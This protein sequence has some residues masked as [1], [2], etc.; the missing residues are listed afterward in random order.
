M[1]GQANYNRWVWWTLI[2]GIVVAIPLILK[3]MSRPSVARQPAIASEEIPPLDSRRFGQ[4]TQRMVRCREHAFRPTPHLQ[5]RDLVT[6]D[7][8]NSVLSGAVPVWFPPTIPSLLHELKLWGVRAS[9]TEEMIGRPVT[10][11][12][13]VDCLLNDKVCRQNTSPHGD[14][15]L[16]DS[17]YGIRVVELGSADA[18]ENRGEAH[19]GQL[20]KA[21]AEGGGSLLQEVSQL[22]LEELGPL[23]IFFK[24]R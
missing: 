10:G 4:N 17:P 19:F 8:L 2:G 21:L 23:R 1:V 13:I 3:F 18:V 22:R 7:D 16:L 12:L 5:L 9:F 14:A 24:M 6:D 15:Y 11:E 20:L